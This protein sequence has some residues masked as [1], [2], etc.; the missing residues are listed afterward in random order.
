MIPPNDY[1]LQ[2]RLRFRSWCGTRSINRKP[3]TANVEIHVLI[4][5]RY[6]LP[7][8]GLCA[9]KGQE[10]WELNLFLSYSTILI[11]V[12]TILSSILRYLVNV[13]TFSHV[14]RIR[15][16]YDEKLKI[17]NDVEVSDDLI[18]MFRVIYF[19]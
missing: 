3:E 16:V 17:Y 8:L 2:E 13:L 7:Q 6:Q 19:H 9:V 11:E 12:P 14:Y 18:I 10:I 1:R 5:F 15:F 4:I